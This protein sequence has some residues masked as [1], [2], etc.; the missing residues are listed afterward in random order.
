MGRVGETLIPLPQTNPKYL[1]VDSEKS[2][3]ADIGERGDEIKLQ[4]RYWETEIDA[5]STGPDWNDNWTRYTQIT[6]GAWVYKR[7]N[8]VPQTPEQDAFPVYKNP[9]NIRMKSHV[10]LDQSEPW[11]TLLCPFKTSTHGAYCAYKKKKNKSY[12]RRLKPKQLWFDASGMA[13]RSVWCRDAH[14]RGGQPHY[15]L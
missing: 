14:M 8:L 11:A 6:C 4:T 5:H 9:Q 3:L 2:S 13:L 1:K 10:K 12:A 7:R 15:K